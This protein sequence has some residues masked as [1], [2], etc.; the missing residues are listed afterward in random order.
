[1]RPFLLGLAAV[2]VVVA[3][4]LLFIFI[5]LNSRPQCIEG[6]PG[7]L[8]RGCP[9]EGAPPSPP[10]FGSVTGAFLGLGVVTVVYGA[11]SVPSPRLAPG[12]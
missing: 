4:V 1:M 8:S 11:F 5:S 9:S 10:I 3:L 6:P 7:V 2:L 12:H